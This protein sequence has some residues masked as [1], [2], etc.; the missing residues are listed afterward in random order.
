MVGI[1]TICPF[2][3]AGDCYFLS[4]FPPCTDLASSGSR[5][6][7][8]KQTLDPLFQ[9]KAAA[10]AVKAAQAAKEMGAVVWT[11]ENP[12]GMLSNLW[13]A[14]NFTFQPAEY[15][16]YL[17]KNDVH[18]IYPT[19]IPARDAYNKRTGIWCS[20]SFKKPPRKPVP[21]VFYT[22]NNAKTGKR[23]RYSPQHKIKAGGVQLCAHIRSLTPRGWALAVL[24]SNC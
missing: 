23:S 22:Y 6:W 14:P 1:A 9:H 20:P 12:V 17:P 16:G 21:I 3:R 8:H 2:G 24:S 13:R 19:R 5:W 4:A 11:V 10:R 18:P 7:A 15:G